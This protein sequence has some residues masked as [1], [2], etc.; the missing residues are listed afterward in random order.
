MIAIAVIFLVPAYYL[1]KSKGYNVAF[2]LIVSAVLSMGVPLMIYAINYPDGF[3][4]GADI[5][6]PLLSLAI[7]WL[8]PPREG[9]PGKKYLKIIFDCPECKGEVNFPRSK[10]GQVELCPKCGEIIT[11]PLDEFSSVPSLPKRIKPNISSGQ[12]CYASF[13]EEMLAAQMQALF[14]DYGIRCE[15]IDGTGGGALPQLSGTQGFKLSI[16]I[17]D[18]DRAIEIE[19]NTN[20]KLETTVK[21]P[22]D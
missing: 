18:W 3:S 13:G 14:E 16:D 8:L 20:H 21:K 2:I 7:V 15:I 11:V 6:F 22:D 10:E 9:A 12:V 4:C 5:T 19:N 1:A 17:D